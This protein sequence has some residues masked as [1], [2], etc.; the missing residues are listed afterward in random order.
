LQFIY[1][2]FKIK[3]YLLDGLRRSMPNLNRIRGR[4][5]GF[6]YNGGIARKSGIPATS[7][8]GTKDVSNATNYGLSKIHN[9][10]SRLGNQGSTNSSRM[11]PPN[12]I[13]RIGRNQQGGQHGIPSRG[14][15][16]RED[17]VVV[18]VSKHFQFILYYD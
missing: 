17:K 11:L 16:T 10:N 4:G 6:G 12:A 18:G 14:S 15:T 3:K 7:H 1:K 8:R 2:Y 13:P 9:S 5:G